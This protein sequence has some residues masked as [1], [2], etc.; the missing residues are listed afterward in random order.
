MCLHGRQHPI[1]T[2]A[3]SIC[4]HT[5][6]VYPQSNVGHATISIWDATIFYLGGTPNICVLQVGTS[7]NRPIEC[8][9]IR[10]LGTGPARLPNY[11]DA[12]ADQSGRRHISTTAKRTTKGD[13]NKIGTIDIIIHGNNEELMIFGK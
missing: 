4:I 6:A 8:P 7:N 5:T 2:C 3:I 1:P 12:K 11:S 10:S 13:I 9:S